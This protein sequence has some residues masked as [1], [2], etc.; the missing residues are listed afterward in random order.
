[1]NKKDTIPF[2]QI[3]NELKFHFGE[4]EKYSFAKAT[5]IISLNDTLRMDTIP[6]F[7]VRFKED[8]RDRT[9]QEKK[10]EIAGWLKVRLNEGNIRV[11]DY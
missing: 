9:K 4:V 6:V 5:E 7:L 11:L 1:M 10:S 8:I 3:S 2:K